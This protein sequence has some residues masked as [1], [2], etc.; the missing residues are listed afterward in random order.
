[1]GCGIGKENIDLASMHGEKNWEIQNP[2]IARIDRVR[3]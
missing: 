2:G 3:D 1:M